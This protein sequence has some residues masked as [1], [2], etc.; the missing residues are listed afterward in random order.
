[1]E[2]KDPRRVLSGAHA[3]SHPPCFND[4]AQYRHWIYLN[5]QA[6]QPRDPSYCLDCTPDFK[7]QMTEEN[8]CTH[9]ETRF[10]IWASRNK[11][12]EVIGVC[13][14]SPMWKRVT[15]GMTLLNWGEDD[16]EN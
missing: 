6:S 15:G 4:A 16:G 5:R 10:V 9:P 3:A 12:L 1:M 14:T 11:E 7:T 2:S 8:R 13:N